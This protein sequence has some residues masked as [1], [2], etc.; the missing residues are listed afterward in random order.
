MNLKS[1]ALV[2]CLLAFPAVLSGQSFT[3][4]TTGAIVTDSTSTQGAAWGDYDNDG[5]LDLFV[6]SDGNNF[7]YA[8]NGDG[9]FELITQSIVVSDGGDSYGA[10][11]G[12]YDN[13]GDLDLFVANDGNNFL[14]AN[15]GNNTFTKITDGAIVNDGG[16]S[17]GC[18]WG[19]YDNDGDLDLYVTN[20]GFESGENDFLYRNNGDRSF[21]KITDA[22]ENTGAFST[23]CNWVDIDNDGD[24]D[25][26]VTTEFGG[27]LLYANN[28]DATFTRIT[29]GDIVNDR[30][31]SYG[32]SWGDYDND[33]DLDVIVA[34]DGFNFLYANNGDGTFT[35]VSGTAITT[36]DFSSFGSSWGDFDNDGDLDLFVA[37]NGT[38]SLF[39]NNGD[40][41]FS[42][43]TGGAIANDVAFSNGC[44]W[45]DIDNDGDLD[46]FVANSKSDFLYLNDGN[47]NNW[48][49]VQLE[50][51]FSNLSAVGAKVSVKATIN[52]TPGWQLR[53]ISGQTGYLSQNSLPAEFGL[54]D[55]AVIDSVKIAWPSSVVQV[56]T[57]VAV[58]QF[59]SVSEAAPAGFLKAD[60]SANPV[61]GTPPLTAQ[62]T[63]KSISYAGTPTISWTWDFQNDGIIDSQEQNPAWVYAASGVFSVKLIVSN[64]VEIDSVVKENYIAVLRFGKI[65]DGEIVNDG[66]PS[67]GSSWGD[68]DDDGDPDLFVANFNTNNFLFTNNG[69]GTFTKINTGGIVSDGGTSSAGTWG[70]YDNDSDLDLFVTNGA[71]EDNFLY[72]NNGDGTFTRITNGVVVTDAGDS[73]GASWADFDN[74]GDLDLFVANNSGENNFLYRNEGEGLFT[75]ITD[76]PVVSDGGFSNGCAWS[77][78][79]NDGDL[80][81]FVANS[82]D[83][84]LYTNNG[85]GTFTKVTTGQIVDDG[86][87]SWG[88]SWGD[89]DNDG[90]FDLFVANH[91]R[92]N[93]ALYRNDGSVFTPITEGEIVNDGGNS[94]GSSWIDF[95]NDGDL[96]LFVANRF[97]K[98]FLYENSGDGSFAKMLRE[99]LVNDKSST[100]G[101]AWAD[102]DLDGDSDVFLANS[103][104]QNNAFFVNLSS[105]NRWLAIQTIGTISNKSAIGTKIRAK[106]I[107]GGEAVWQVQEISGQTGY[108]GQNSL[109]VEFG[110]GDATVVDSLQLEWPSGVVQVL[111]GVATNQFLTVVEESATRAFLTFRLDLR[112]VQNVGLFRGDLGMRPFLSIFSEAPALNV[113]LSDND[114]D[115]IWIARVELAAPDTV[116]YAFAIDPDGDGINTNN[117]WVFELGGANG[118][119]SFELSGGGEFILEPVFFDNFPLKQIASD[120]QALVTKS[121]LPGDS[122]EQ[123]FVENS[124]QTYLAL[125]FAALDQS[126]LIAVRNYLHGAGGTPPAGI[127]VLATNAYWGVEMVPA[128]AAFNADLSINYRVFTGINDA[129]ALRLLKRQGTGNPWEIVD[130]SVDQS[131]KVVSA[132]GLADL[133]QWTFGSTSAANSLQPQL[134]VVR[135]P[136]PPDGEINVSQ[137]PRLSWFP[138]PVALTYDLFFWKAA[139]SKPVT[140]RAANL[141]EAS[142]TV[143]NQLIL[144]ETYN[145]QVVARNIYGET[146]G[147][148][149]SFTVRNLPDLVVDLVQT[150][151]DA[152]SAQ[153][154]EVSWR[155]TNTGNGATNAPEWR[156]HIFLST[157]PQF[158]FDTASQLGD[159]ANLAF[160]QPGESYQNSQRFTMPRTAI[161]EHY[162]FVQTDARNQMQESDENNNRGRNVDA[163]QVELT[164]P[165]DLQVTSLV[166][167]ENGFSGELVNVTWTVANLGPGPTDAGEWFDAIFFSRDSVFNQNATQLGS[168]FKHEG[169]LDTSGAYTTGKL[170]RLPR[171]I[172]GLAYI[173]VITD[174]AD[175]VFEF[176]QENNNT[177]RDS[178][179]VTLTP[180]PDLA[181][182]QITIPDSARS[183]E[184]ISIGWRVENQGP[185][186]TV[187]GF[188][189][190]R[191]FLS[192]LPE[193]NPDSVVVLGSTSRV[194]DIDAGASYEDGRIL[195]IPNGISGDYYVFVKTDADSQVFEHTF[196]ANNT[197]RSD[198]TL[199]IELS[200]W[201]DLQVSSVQ[202]P[203][204]PT[205]GDEIEVTWEV[206][207]NGVDTDSPVSWLDRIYLSSSP[208]L[209]RATASLLLDF[210]NTR[211]LSAGGSYSQTRKANLPP[212]ISG[213]YYILLE[214]DAQNSI[215]EHID[216]A[217]NVGRSDSLAVAPYPPVD[218]IVEN[219]SAPQTGSSGQPVTVGF[220]VKNI[221]EARTLGAFWL[222]EVFLSK[223]QTLERNADIRIARVQRNE[224]LETNRSYSRSR[225]ITLPNGISGAYFVIVQTDAE[226]QVGEA[227]EG[228]NI[229][230]SQQPVAIEFTP[231]PDLQ[232]AQLLA[233][234]EGV[235]GQPLTVNWQV[236]NGGD[237][238]TQADV[239]F[240]AVFLS[241]NTTLDISDRR[242]G[243][244][245]RDPPL[246][247]GAFY[248]DSVEVSIPL[249]ASGTYY[250]LLKTDNRNDLFEGSAEENN[251]L[252][253]PISIRLPE[254]SD[255]V[256]TE[257]TL[258]DSAMPGQELTVS[259]TV[260]NQGSN[261]AE[262]YM[263]DAV[264]FSTDDIWDI[265]DA[266]FGIT[267]RFINL[268]PGGS[269]QL[270][271]Q[272]NLSKAFAVD[273]A[274]N[275]TGE[276]PGLTPGSYHAIVRTDLRN[277]IR[278][279][280]NLNNTGASEDSL[281]VSIPQLT[282]GVPDTSSLSAGGIRFYRVQ[283]ASGLDLR[284]TLTS[285]NPL[286]TNEMYVAFARAPSLDEFDFSA[287]EPFS[288]N[289]ELLLPST[290]AGSYF[291]MI[292]TRSNVAQNI[293]LEANALAF[294]ILSITPDR[295][296]AVGR[297]TC[298]VT[299]AGF[300]ESIKAFL[301][302]TSD[303]LFEGRFLQLISSTQVKFRWNLD[304]IPV[305]RYDV[306]LMHNKSKIAELF[307]G[308]TVESSHIDIIDLD[309]VG[310]GEVREGSRGRFTFNFRNS[311]NV[312][313]PYF[314]AQVLVPNN[315]EV[316]SVNATP[317]LKKI[318]DF[319]PGFKDYIDARF[320]E[321]GVRMQ[322]ISIFGRDIPPNE[323]FQ[324]EFTAARISGDFFPFILGFERIGIEQFIQEES[325][326]IEDL[327]LTVLD[328]PAQFE[329]RIQLLAKNPLAFKEFVF[330][331][332]IESAMIDSLDLYN[333]PSISGEFSQLHLKE[334]GY[335]N[336]FSG[337]GFNQ[338]WNRKTNES[339]LAA[340]DFVPCDFFSNLLCNI[341]FEAL[342]CIPPAVA[343]GTSGAIPAVVFWGLGCTAASNSFCYFLTQSACS[344][345]VRSY[346]PNDILGPS[347]FGDQ[348]WIAQTQSLPYTIRF[349]NDPELATAPAQVVKVTQKLDETVDARSFRLGSF[350]FG[351]FRFEVPENRSFY[352]QRLDVR[353]SLGVFV[354]VNAG[355]D[356][357]KNEAFWIFRS[358]DPATGQAPTNPLAGFLPVNDTTGVGDG[359]VSYTVRPASEVATA[360]SID[361]QAR[362]V[363]DINEP[364]DT[365]AIFNTID[366]DLPVSSMEPSASF[367]DSTSF[368]IRWSGKDVG[369]GLQSFTIFVSEDKAPFQPLASDISDSSLIFT[370]D[371]GK[372]YEFFSIA[373]D[374][375]GNL[376]SMKAQAELTVSLVTS[377]DDKSRLA[378]PAQFELFQSYP[379][380]FN[381][382]ANI[383]YAL[384]KPSDV[385]IEIYNILGQR[386]TVLVDEQQEAGYH[387]IQWG[388]KNDG[389]ELVA[390]GT[391]FYRIEAG[392][393]VKTRKMLLLR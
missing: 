387:I 44:A 342:I 25:L 251:V 37:N 26:F 354:D 218:L 101:V 33:G 316:V 98:N 119:R 261:I 364:I 106:A 27:N 222:D 165:P 229:A 84:F 331:S 48:L 208:T 109:I 341:A 282:L 231:V 117:E 21:V 163:I 338:A 183:G 296:G 191:I 52:G 303:S 335:L 50:G 278:E 158:S 1:T 90:D 205:A 39:M 196:E 369:S 281:N 199:A 24:L 66:V 118:G 32:A 306:V 197:G 130:T 313:I 146:A 322:I 5:D 210:T 28:G 380:P 120:Y 223:N 226:N 77:D 9:T 242:L 328:N 372:S 71:G 327:R 113:A 291:I 126:S 270:K 353:D 244:V 79:D 232:V 260:Q 374:N 138:S 60:F 366:A 277:N 140:P 34:N 392:D 246:E 346:D 112:S 110:L 35:K 4:I 379:N 172:T 180:P 131:R 134:P 294:S 389:G 269:L 76:G 235:A 93:N 104:F 105:K 300:S 249:F 57:G 193:F 252:G 237:G 220:T 43:V 323:S 267:R 240:D 18:A 233:P 287:A 189:R 36:E 170:V 206:V 292:L 192:R 315:G 215:F 176:A 305:G 137:A 202:A 173:F 38:S 391:Y 207:N 7:L 264:Y 54:G 314:R 148:T 386:I 53:E 330:Q 157:N 64:G 100:Q 145:W 259:Y 51:T 108:L 45:G 91:F 310:P 147:P 224:F 72:S 181:I 65:A 311:G 377:V 298:T 16:V 97:R 362:I 359:F 228:N 274:G 238:R 13:D 345:V 95:D 350:G 255:L 321:N 319:I 363:F 211:P 15:N 175:R 20:L 144:G 143:E 290:Q 221:G 99:D 385:K 317:N 325:K 293:S 46:L 129:E 297:V 85:D 184:S 393:F 73:R 201:P 383:K 209:N 164:P 309:I 142:Y 253:A 241:E 160:L 41:T 376:E 227:G 375:A 61:Q 337:L 14:Y 357:T 230:V 68:Y 6:A 295:G 30:G 370:G 352:Q 87:N 59:L 10:T 75:R 178:I 239:W 286:A 96:D 107:I 123:P 82:G 31:E 70:D 384:P 187:E 275:I 272:V 92:T 167:P 179:N 283:V 132:N 307:N 368:E 263:N 360:D 139:D 111:T 334:Y 279:S 348:K 351:S 17:S 344:G 217:N 168:A 12:D 373:K 103:N 381:P 198:T 121:F 225:T 299:G 247:P 304:Q 329:S 114:A 174:V 378:L 115:S 83:N 388:G 203:P 122:P 29:Q 213:I 102:F 177:A 280:D 135:T 301:R 194:L 390:T 141:S 355:I 166:V 124:D 152:F 214:T 200:P 136:A 133:S 216:E 88:A 308:F 128:S 273:E 195:T 343:I 156:D 212:D 262:G 74:D 336:E 276:L 265:D 250:L 19:D 171:T 271:A 358:V 125:D 256:V 347:G 288:A 149:W 151:P 49:N 365:P 356:V 63:D 332:Y 22:V 190:D 153:S 339:I 162:I 47:S 289:Q 127:E 8:N 78:Y 318:S 284:V 258:P 302:S 234:S 285:D 161:G 236:I 361:A 182:T 3:K 169:A 2:S 367:I 188:W 80:D 55:A 23:G 312:D 320:I 243:T 248:D 116:Q 94:S 62:F 185:G 257:I 266:L 40:G 56:L 69:D 254:P 245:Q 204:S 326:K 333:T 155:I 349:E 159:F 81:L 340:L 89:F 324:F 186:A 11:W 371:I 58:N 268:P 67:I 42:K 219:V 382:A 86:R 154:F 150:P